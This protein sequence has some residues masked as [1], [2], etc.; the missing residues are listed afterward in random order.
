MVSLFKKLYSYRE[1]VTLFAYGI[2]IGDVLNLVQEVILEWLKHK[3]FNELVQRH[4]EETTEQEEI[5][6]EQTSRY[7]N[8]SLKD[9]FFNEVVKVINDDENITKS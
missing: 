6:V 8:G 3:R 2:V 7:S 5:P 1:Y 9:P 4:V